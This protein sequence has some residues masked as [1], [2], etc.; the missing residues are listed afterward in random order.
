[1]TKPQA[2][3]G[4][5]KATNKSWQQWMNELDEMGARDMTHTEIARKLYDQLDGKLENHGWWAQ[6]ISVAYEQQIGRCVPGQLAN[7]KF[8]I[9]VSKTVGLSSEELFECAVAWMES[10]HDLNNHVVNK[11][12]SSQTPKRS[13]WRCNFDDG[14]KLTATVEEA[15]E[16]SKIVVAVT[17]VPSKG[18]ADEWKT[19][20]QEHII[21]LSKGGV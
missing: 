4:I 17:D 21:K 10:Q 13:N 18:L 12:R 7:G 16:K 15:G 14:S 1:M 9:A 5:E 2:T 20:W 19:F 11:P 6:G 3:K 8:E